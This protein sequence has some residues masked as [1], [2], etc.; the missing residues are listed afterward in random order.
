[1]RKKPFIYVIS[2]DLYVMMSLSQKF[3]KFGF[4]KE[5]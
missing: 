2:E 5:D 4:S 1:M 3:K